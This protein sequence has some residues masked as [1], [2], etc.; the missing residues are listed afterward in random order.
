MNAA[1]SQLISLQYLICSSSEN[2]RTASLETKIHANNSST[3]ENNLKTTVTGTSL[4]PQ[5][6]TTQIIE[7][8]GGYPIG[9]FCCVKYKRFWIGTET[10]EVFFLDPAPSWLNTKLNEALISFSISDEFGFFCL[11]CPLLTQWHCC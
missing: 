7:I 5:E 8:P 4:Y 1:T 11:S 3:H 9:P 10:L 6:Y 2:M